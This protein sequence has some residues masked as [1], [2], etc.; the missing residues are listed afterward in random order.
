MPKTHGF[1]A[2]QSASTLPLKIIN[3]PNEKFDLKL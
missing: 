3:K 2:P 1:V